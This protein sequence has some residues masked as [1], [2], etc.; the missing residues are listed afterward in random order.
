[1]ALTKIRSSVSW[2][3]V[4][5]CLTAVGDFFTDCRFFHFG[6][7]GKNSSTRFS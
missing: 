7:S 2:I 1:M 5:H 6:E 3:E 4:T